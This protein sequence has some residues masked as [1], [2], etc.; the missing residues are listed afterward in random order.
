MQKRMRKLAVFLVNLHTSSCVCLMIVCLVGPSGFKI[1]N[2]DIK[3]G[4]LHNTSVMFCHYTL[5]KMIII[6]I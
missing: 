4:I 2:V 5:A 1:I 3:S 6:I